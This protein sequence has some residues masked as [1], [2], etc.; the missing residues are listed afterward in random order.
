[1][2][3]GFVYKLVPTPEQA[4]LMAQLAGVCR[5]IWNLALEQRRDH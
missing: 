5:L 4:A 2:F 1:M 3:R